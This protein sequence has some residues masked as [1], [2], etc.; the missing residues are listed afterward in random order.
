MTWLDLALQLGEH[1]QA[2][3]LIKRH[4]PIRNARRFERVYEVDVVPDLVLTRTEGLD[5][6]R[7]GSAGGVQLEIRRQDAHRKHGG[8]RGD[9]VVHELACRNAL[10]LYPLE[11]CAGAH[12]PL[13]PVSEVPHFGHARGGCGTNQSNI[14]IQLPLVLSSAQL[15]IRLQ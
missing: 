8:C 14:P 3:M 9:V 10:A 6:S 13:H 1:E 5:P 4:P 15:E 12:L 2:V 11:Q 7:T